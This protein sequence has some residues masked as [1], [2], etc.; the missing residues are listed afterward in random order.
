MHV[1]LLGSSVKVVSV[2]LVLLSLGSETQHLEQMAP[3][4]MHFK[5]VTGTL[6]GVTKRGQYMGESLS[7]VD[8]SLQNL[9]LLSLSSLHP[10]LCIRGG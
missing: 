4:N 7:H 10:G 9:H 2:D 8:P 1:R 3:V 5:E 6:T